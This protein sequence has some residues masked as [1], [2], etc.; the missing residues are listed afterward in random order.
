MRTD[1]EAD[2][3]TAIVALRK[4]AKA[5]E[6]WIFCTTYTCGDNMRKNQ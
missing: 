2:M 4:F 5:P 1:G 6:K 3:T